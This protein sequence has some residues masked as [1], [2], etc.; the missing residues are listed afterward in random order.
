[1]EVQY[2]EPHSSAVEQ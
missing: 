2:F 1:V